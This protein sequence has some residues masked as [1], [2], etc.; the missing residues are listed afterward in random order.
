VAH[1]LEQHFRQRRA[2]LELVPGL[3]VDHRAERPLHLVHRLT[4][5]FHTGTQH[6]A[7]AA[8]VGQQRLQI[9]L[10]KNAVR[11]A[12]HQPRVEHHAV[13]AAGPSV[14]RPVAVQHA[15][16]DEQPLAL[17]QSV[18]FPGGSGQDRALADHQH[19]QFLMPMP[20]DRLGLQIVMVAGDGERCRAVFQQFPGKIVYDRSAYRQCHLLFISIFGEIIP[21]FHGNSAFISCRL[22]I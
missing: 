19:F 17:F 8:G 13:Q 14:Q 12:A 11:A 6:G 22:M 2:G 7:G 9:F 10:P 20:R 15:C 18:F 5:P 3:L 4:L 16:V 1:Q 21:E